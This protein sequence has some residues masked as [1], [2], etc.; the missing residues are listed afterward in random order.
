MI[1]L[2]DALG[3]NHHLWSRAGRYAAGQSLHTSSCGTC[4]VLPSPF[5][6]LVWSLDGGRGWMALLLLHPIPSEH[7]FSGFNVRS[8]EES[9]GGG[10]LQ[11]VAQRGG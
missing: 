2:A 7:P 3:T 9:Q 1:S 11:Q 5:Q 10:T 4:P 8:L 6:M